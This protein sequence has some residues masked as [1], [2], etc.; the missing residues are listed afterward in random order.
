IQGFAVWSGGAR[1]APDWRNNDFVIPAQAG[2]ALAFALAG[3][4]WLMHEK[5]APT[6]AKVGA[7]A[8]AKARAIPACAGMTSSEQKVP[9]QN[10]NP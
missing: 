6:E 4:S 10:P 7:R 1:R 9:G 3:K 5:G 2:I 8:K